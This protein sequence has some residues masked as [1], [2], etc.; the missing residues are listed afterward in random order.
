MRQFLEIAKV[1]LDFVIEQHGFGRC[2]QPP[3]ASL[4]E[5][6]ADIFLKAPQQ[7]AHA[8]LRDVH[9]QA[10][11]VTEAVSTMAVKASICRRLMVADF[12]VALRIPNAL[13]IGKAIALTHDMRKS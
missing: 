6:E 9:G 11:A 5:I 10:A 2:Q 12:D 8:R 1:F 3:F 4:E 7:P 13:V